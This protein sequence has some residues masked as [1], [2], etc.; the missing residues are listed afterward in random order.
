MKS[1]EGRQNCPGK[2][3]TLLK[4]RDHMFSSGIHQFYCDLCSSM[5]LNEVVKV[6]PEE[7]RSLDAFDDCEEDS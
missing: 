1:G 5:K 7:A 2:S 4:N 6:E 3:S